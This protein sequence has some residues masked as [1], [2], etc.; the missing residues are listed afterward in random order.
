MGSDLAHLKNNGSPLKT[1]MNIFWATNVEEITTAIKFFVDNVDSTYISHGEVQSG[2]STD[3]ENWSPL[4]QQVLMS[5]F[6]GKD[7]RVGLLTHD[8]KLCAIAFVTTHGKFAVLEDIVVDKDQRGL[9]YGELLY[10]WIEKQ[11]QETGINRIFLESKL[12]NQRAHKFLESLGFQP[13]S[14]EMFKD[15]K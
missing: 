12:N 2:R 9:N 5:E 11:L 3:F 7:G 15:I 6:N 4:L 14:V 13:C 10:Y 1:R 8:N